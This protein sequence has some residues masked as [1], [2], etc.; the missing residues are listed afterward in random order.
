[1]EKT[2]SGQLLKSFLS[3]FWLRPENALTQTNRALSLQKYLVQE[4]DCAIDI[5]C[6][7]GVFSYI[8]HGGILS[9]TDDMF[10]SIKIDKPRTADF[11]HF[12]HFEE[13]SHTINPLS[14]PHNFFHTGIDWK[15]TMLKK[16]G[17]LGAYTDLVLHDN[18]N[19]LKFQDDT[20]TYVYS[21]SIYW[22]DKIKEHATDIVRVCNSDGLILLHVKTRAML[23]HTAA[24]YA[25]ELGKNFADVIDAGRLNSYKGLLDLDQ[26]IDMF[27]SVPGVYVEDVIPVYNGATAR[28]WDIGLRPLFKPL[29]SMTRKIPKDELSE[30]KEEWVDTLH[31]LLQDTLHTPAKNIKDAMEFLIVIRKL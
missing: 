21:N 7:D 8:C 24:V 25:P 10:Q 13:D 30:I 18:N 5:S 19:K 26:Y 31:N 16:A 9:P 11:D 6:G 17:V 4:T 20:F 2:V 29:F 22:V 3:Y 23:L 12:D 28:I 1:M 15:S 14:K 27:R